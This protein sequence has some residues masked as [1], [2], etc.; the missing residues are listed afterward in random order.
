MPW[1]RCRALGDSQSRFLPRRLEGRWQGP[2][3]R[4][5]VS[6]GKRSRGWVGRRSGLCVPI[7]FPARRLGVGSRQRLEEGEGRPGLGL[8]TP[9][10]HCASFSAREEDPT[11][12]EAPR[13]PGSHSYPL[14]AWLW[15]LLP[16]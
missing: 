7:P 15:V 11:L 10:L 14:Q 16:A 1:V 5:G 8:G 9:E 12:Q 13:L 4:L 3:G 2:S 6:C